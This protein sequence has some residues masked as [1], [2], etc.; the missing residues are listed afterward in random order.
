MVWK[1]KNRKFAEP[2]MELADLLDRTGYGSRYEREI[3]ELLKSDPEEA[4][5]QLTS[6]RMW[7]GSGSLIDL[8]LRPGPYQTSDDWERD[9]RL[10]DKYML[11]ILRNLKAEGVP[12]RFD[13]EGTESLLV[14]AS[15]ES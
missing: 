3:I 8:I 7:G 1:P 5:K 10:K 11:K 2:L 14:K 9:N 6:V 12:L 15:G 4:L 13:V